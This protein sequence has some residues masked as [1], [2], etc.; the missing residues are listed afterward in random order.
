LSE[1][2]I[3]LLCT[4]INPWFCARLTSKQSLDLARSQQQKN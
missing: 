4:V 3:G 1:L 2:L